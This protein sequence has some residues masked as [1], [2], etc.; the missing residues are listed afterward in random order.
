MFPLGLFRRRRRRGSA[1]SLIVAIP[2]V[3]GWVAYDDYSRSR[4]KNEAWQGTI[5]RSYSERGFLSG[6]RSTPHR[7]W[8]VRTAGGEVQTVR[9]YSRD[10]WSDGHPGLWAIKR[11]G[12]LNPELIGR[13]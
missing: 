6:R 7:Y 12:E 11:S 3:L 4:Q 8:D 2:F 13:R 9:I 5:V 10:L 1:K